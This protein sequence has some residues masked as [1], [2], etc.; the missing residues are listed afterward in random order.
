MIAAGRRS[1]WP[2]TAHAQLGPTSEAWEFGARCCL[3]LEFGRGTMA[4]GGAEA[5]PDALDIA[6]CDLKALEEHQHVV[7]NCDRVGED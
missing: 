4:W 7:T 2:G 3:T 1:Q 5:W 6:N